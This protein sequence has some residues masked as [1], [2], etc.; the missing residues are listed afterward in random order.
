[1]LLNDFLYP[2]PVEKALYMKPNVL[3]IGLNYT[4]I[5]RATAPDGS[6]FEQEYSTAVNS[7]PTKGTYNFHFYCH[8]M[9][10]LIV[11]V[12]LKRW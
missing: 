1:M 9:K 7:P 8:C 6:F 12:H 11:Y 3:S 4:L 2:V 10:T 5:V